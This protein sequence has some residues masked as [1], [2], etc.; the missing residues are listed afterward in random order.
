MIQE[1]VRNGKLSTIIFIRDKNAKGQET[2]PQVEQ[3]IRDRKQLGAR[4]LESATIL[5]KAPI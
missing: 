3:K 1:M 4:A 5:G 2:Q